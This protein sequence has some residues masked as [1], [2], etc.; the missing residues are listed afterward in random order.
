MPDGLAARRAATGQLNAMRIFLSLA[1]L[2]LLSACVSVPTGPS[3]MVLPGS[4]KNFDQFRVDDFDCRQFASSQVGGTTA[5]QA[6]ENTVVKS[7]VVGT[8]IGALAG[9]IV[10]GRGSAA[11]GAGAGLIVGT[12]AGA[13]ASSGSQY[14]LQRRYDNSYVQCMYSR[15]H[16]VPSAGRVSNAPRPVYA[17]PPPAVYYPP[18]QSYGAPP[19][20]AGTPPPPP[21]GA[22]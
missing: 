4:S 7:A 19:P 13:G 22:N 9:A 11:S 20:P 5:D 10:G 21:P 17:P 16:Q 12:A 14:S 1:G 2:L 8:A 15:G 3:V 18:S 6:A